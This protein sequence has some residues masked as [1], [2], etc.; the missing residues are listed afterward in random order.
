MFADVEAILC[1]WLHTELGVRCVTDLPAD[2]QSVLPVVQVTRFGGT[3]TDYVRDNPRVDID[4]YWPPDANANPDR[5]GAI[6]FAEQVHEAMIWNLTGRVFDGAQV[7][8]VRTESAP[9]VQRYDDTA[10]RRVTATYALTIR[11][12]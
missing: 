4:V 1:G 11:A 5:A 12:I 7:K 6:G 10:L 2:L 9:S 8:Q 3:R